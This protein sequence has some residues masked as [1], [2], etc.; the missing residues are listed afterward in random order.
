M[1]TDKKS[2]EIK[3]K[4]KAIKKKDKNEEKDNFKKHIETAKK[5]GKAIMVATNFISPAKASLRPY[6]KNGKK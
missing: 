4:P 2:K 1:I 5:V 6:M 3:F